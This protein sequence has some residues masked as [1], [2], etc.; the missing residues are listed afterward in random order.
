[1]FSRSSNTFPGLTWSYNYTD[2]KRPTFLKV[3]RKKKS[4]EINSFVFSKALKWEDF[5]PK[6]FFFKLFLTGLFQVFNF[7]SFPQTYLSREVWFGLFVFS[8]P[9]SRF[10]LGRVCTLLP[11][12]INFNYIFIFVFIF[13]LICYFIYCSLEQKNLNIRELV[14]ILCWIYILKRRIITQHKLCI[15]LVTWTYSL[16]TW[17]YSLVT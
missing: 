15:S 16:V 8:C 17:T 1:M 13:C 5:F 9:D 6:L 11:K 7:M 14:F 12:Y 4:P 10:G 3:W 2:K